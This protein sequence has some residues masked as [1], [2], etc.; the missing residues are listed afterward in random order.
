MN[1]APADQNTSKSDGAVSGR[2]VAQAASATAVPA[3]VSQCRGQ[4]WGSKVILFT[5]VHG[6]VGRFGSIVDRD[7]YVS[8][9][10]GA[11]YGRLLRGED[12]E[13]SDDRFATVIEGIW[14][15]PKDTE[16]NIKWVRDYHEATAPFS[17]EGGYINFQS[18]DDA[19]NVEKN[20]GATYTRL[21]NIKKK[22][23]PDN[24]F[25]MNQN[26][27]PARLVHGV[28]CRSPA[29]EA[30]EPEATAMPPSV[31]RHVRIPRPRR[32]RRVRLQGSDVLLELREGSP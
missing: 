3:S 2:D 27:P 28:A 10:Y 22:Y 5:H 11:S 29:R 20:Y 12:N 15:D 8:I 25:R 31:L 13:Q 17:R 18:A 4:A 32:D 1:R 24:L 30:R 16:A 19:G 9:S 14:P 23:D 26:I 21:A 6:E 7:P